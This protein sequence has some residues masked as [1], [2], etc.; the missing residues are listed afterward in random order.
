MELRVCFNIILH[1]A[2]GEEQIIG[3]TT[4][5]AFD[6]NGK[7]KQGRQELN[8]WPFYKV[9]S[10]IASVNEYYGIPLN[11]DENPY[12]CTLIVGFPI[13]VEDVYWSLRDE[14]CMS[15]L[16]CPSSAL[17]K[18]QT[19]EQGE[20][21]TTLNY[22]GR[23]TSWKATP[24]TEELA[25]LDRLLKFDPLTRGLYS[26]EDKFILLKCRNY[27]KNSPSAFP[28]FLCAID[29]SDPDQVREVY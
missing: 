27:Y 11:S 8:V 13:F 7:L 23:K 1:S 28:I 9:D 24:N 6:E 25:Q 16:G 21:R 2:N 17:S 12:Y 15:M 5:E 19:R 14:K 3:S 29:W 18:T 10:R 4:T 26:D 22:G 20:K